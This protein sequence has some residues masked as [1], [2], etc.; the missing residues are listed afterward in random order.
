MSK[1]GPKDHEKNREFLAAIY[2]G[3]SKAEQLLRKDAKFLHYR[4]IAG[5][6]PFHY[7]VVESDTERAT[8]L[9]EWGADVNTQ[10][11]FGATPLHHAVMLGKL[12][13]V[14]WL[15]ERGA[16]LDLKNVNGETAL[17]VATSNEK[18]GIFQFLISLPRKHP[19][20]YYY[21]D[22][23][24]QGIYDDRELVMR[25]HLISLGL[26]ERYV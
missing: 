11:D 13:L 4:S 24:S 25:S 3:S 15:V 1:T 18:A 10:D 8:K 20:D 16:S 26:T 14:K 17:T 5:E 6:T 21:D 19:I 2:E 22:L 23:S 9:L 7:L 12:D